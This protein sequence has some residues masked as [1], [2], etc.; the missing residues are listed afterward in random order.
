[1]NGIPLPTL[2][3]YIQLFG[4]IAVLLYLAYTKKIASDDARVIKDAADRAAR[5][6]RRAV[7]AAQ[8]AA[9]KIEEQGEVNVKERAVQTAKIEEVH[10][11]LNGGW[12]AAK[13]EIADLKAEVSRLHGVNK[14]LLEHPPDPPSRLEEIRGQQ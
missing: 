8:I 7:V 5:R 10:Q 1:M 14:D 9:K 6:G 4:F 12:A 11:S 13:Q 3:T 2:T